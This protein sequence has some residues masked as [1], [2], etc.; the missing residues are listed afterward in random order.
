MRRLLI[1]SLLLCAFSVTDRAQ[2]SSDTP[3]TK[4]DVLK[5]MD[6]MHLRS[7]LVQYFDGI[8][9]QARVGA[10]EGFRQKVP[11]ASP[12]QLAEVDKFADG[13]FKDMPIGEMLDAMVPI[14]QKHLSKGD[15]E[16]I[17]AFYS[18]PVGRKLL[19]EQP[20]MMQESMEVGGKIGRQRIGAMSE[21]IDE[22]ISKLAQEE[23]KKKS[24]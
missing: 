19:R 4:E 21:K 24:K 18:S 22:F 14:Y 12:E 23:E 6:L 16:S 1:L 17:L 8:G 2:T 9:K 3:P 13:I 15:L 5:F 7:T 10:A 20:A 11:D